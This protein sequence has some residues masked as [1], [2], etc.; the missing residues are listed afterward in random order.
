VND[1][2]LGVAAKLDA[3]LPEI[4]RTF[5]K[6]VPQNLDPPAFFIDTE[7]VNCRRYPNRR[8]AYEYRIVVHYF[9]RSVQDHDEMRDVGLR[10]FDALEII[11]LPGEILTRG[12]KRSWTI[13]P[14]EQK[15]I[16]YFYVTYSVVRI[17][18]TDADLMREQNVIFKEVAKSG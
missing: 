11:G 1:V 5:T 13:K 9:P 7:A 6:E 15:N 18:E 3:E 10:L 8:V 12:R 16:L 14:Q 4:G 17:F 2:V